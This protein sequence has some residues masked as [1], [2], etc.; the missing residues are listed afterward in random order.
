MAQRKR[1][2]RR[3]RR[4]TV[5]DSLV[6]DGSEGAV[7]RGKDVFVLGL[8]IDSCG[9]L[10]QH[11][12]PDTIGVSEANKSDPLDEGDAAV[13]SLDLL[14]ELLSRLED[15]RGHNLLLEIVVLV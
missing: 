13:R 12:G 7:L 10:P 2:G 9:S 3:R 5:P 8:P 4:L 6:S 14:H 11:Q 1:R 15:N